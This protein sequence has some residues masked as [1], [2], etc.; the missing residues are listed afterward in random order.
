MSTNL[1]VGEYTRLAAHVFQMLGEHAAEIVHRLQEAELERFLPRT[2][3][4]FGYSYSDRQEERAFSRALEALTDRPE[5]FIG[6]GTAVHEALIEIIRL[7]AEVFTTSY[8]RDEDAAEWRRTHP[9]KASARKEAHK[10]ALA[11]Q[12]RVTKVA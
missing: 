12:K 9:T 8:F 1:T 11:E 6:D 2:Q 7:S 3:D 4:A 10:K 5:D